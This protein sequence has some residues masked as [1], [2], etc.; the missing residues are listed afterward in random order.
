MV[1]VPQKTHLED[2]VMAYNIID[3]GDAETS[4]KPV[5]GQEVSVAYRLWRN[6][7]QETLIA[8]ATV[9]E[10]YKFVLGANSVIKG[11]EIAVRSLHIGGKAN[12]LVPAD[13]AY[14]KVG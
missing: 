3:L 10:P 12:F 1:K 7:D 14:G 6:I 5:D 2:G 13:Q 9:D 4:T 8:S 11:F